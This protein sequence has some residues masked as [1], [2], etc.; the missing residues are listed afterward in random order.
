MK[1]LQEL[2]S[3]EFKSWDL[4]SQ[5]LDEAKNQAR[6][7]FPP[8]AK[9]AS[10]SLVS[11]Q[12]SLTSVLGAIVFHTGGL[13]IDHGWLRI[14]G[15]GNQEFPRDIMGWNQGKSDSNEQDIPEFLLVA[16]DV[17]GGFFALNG[18]KFEGDP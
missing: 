1:S 12:Q 5:W 17:L 13:T 10:Q 9:T 4:I 18:G 15:S 8:D 2:I 6:P 3:V 16:D 7:I 14:L 11:L